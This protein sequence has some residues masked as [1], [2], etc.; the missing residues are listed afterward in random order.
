MGGGGGI[1]EGQE[2]TAP[3]GWLVKQSVH[4]WRCGRLASRLCWAGP[5]Q[6]LGCAHQGVRQLATSGWE[7]A[8]RGQSYVIENQALV[9]VSSFNYPLIIKQPT[10][11]VASSKHSG[12]ACLV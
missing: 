11:T 8:H 12:V 7:T 9:G 4:A 10:S 6:A 3:P 5:G 2:V 1:L